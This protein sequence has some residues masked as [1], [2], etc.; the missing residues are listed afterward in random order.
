[1]KNW[2]WEVILWTN[3]VMIGV[4]VDVSLSYN[5]YLSEPDRFIANEAN[6][7]FVNFLTMGSIP[8]GLIVCILAILFFSTVFYRIWTVPIKF[9][10]PCRIVLWFFACSYLIA[11]CSASSSWYL[12]D[13]YNSWVWDLHQISNYCSIVGLVAVGG[14]NIFFIMMGRMKERCC[15]NCGVEMATLTG[16]WKCPECHCFQPYLIGRN[17]Q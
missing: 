11:R 4:L 15:P 6:R 3:V 17:E 13:F 8:F 1:M 5:I 12:T 14:I 2:I 10:L 9:R 7:E 16:G